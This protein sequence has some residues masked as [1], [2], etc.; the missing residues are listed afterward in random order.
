[1]KIAIMTLGCKV[2]KYE[3]DALMY[4][5]NLK[6]FDTTDSLEFADVYI[7]NSCA[8][9]TP[10]SLLSLSRTGIDDSE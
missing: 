5:L 6:G 4:N 1:M 9:T 10:I 7:I 3:S 2:N 8:V